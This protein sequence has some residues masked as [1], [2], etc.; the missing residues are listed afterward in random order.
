MPSKGK[1]TNKLLSVKLVKFLKLPLSQLFPRLS[2]KVLEKSK[3]YRKNASSKNKKTME[4]TKLSYIQVTLKSINNIL[5]IK[6]NFPKLSNKKIEELNK[7]IFSKSKKPK[8]KIN[9]TTKSSSCKQVIISMGNDNVKRFMIASSEHITNL[10]QTLKG[11]KSDIIIDFIYINYRRLIITSNR[12]ISLLDISIINNY[13]KNYNNIDTNNIQDVWLLQSKSYLKILSILYLIED[14]NILINSKEMEV[15]IRS[16]H[17]FNNIKIMSKPC[18]VKVFL[19]S[20]I[21]IV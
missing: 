14:T 3:F 10:N 16:I 6:E 18:I 15:F 9:M 12:V 5:K 19:K 2:K 17:I 4:M 7:S 8:S 20:N 21:A 1:K 11:I 13:V